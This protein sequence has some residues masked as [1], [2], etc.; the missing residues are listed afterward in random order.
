MLCL[1][2]ELELCMVSLTWALFFPMYT[3]LPDEQNP[4]KGTNLTK[5]EETPEEGTE[6]KSEAQR[7]QGRVTPQCKLYLNGNF[8]E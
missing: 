1:E 8:L 3:L 7:N 6:T 4:S 5:Q 2:R